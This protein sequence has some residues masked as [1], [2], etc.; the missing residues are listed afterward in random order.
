VNAFGEQELS[1]VGAGRLSTATSAL[2]RHQLENSMCL[3][4]IGSDIG[5]LL[6]NDEGIPEPL[7]NATCRGGSTNVEDYEP[8]GI[9]ATDEAPIE[10]A[11]GK[12]R[13]SIQRMSQGFSTG[14][15][16]IVQDGAD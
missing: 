15:C 4:I 10:I 2:H 14:T 5:R 8:I 16:L 1:A 12:S 13:N 9:G 3:S 11:A 7:T 6:I